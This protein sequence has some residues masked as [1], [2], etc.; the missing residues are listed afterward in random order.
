MVVVSNYLEIVSNI[1]NGASVVYGAIL[2]E[3]YHRKE[4]TGV[5]FRFEHREANGE[6][7]VCGKASSSL[8]FGR[9]VCVVWDSH[10]FFMYPTMLNFE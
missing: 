2:E 7:H 6:A 8:E 9:H 5:V 1:N 4:F 3:M 10:H